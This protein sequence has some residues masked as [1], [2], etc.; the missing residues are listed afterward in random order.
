MEPATFDKLGPT[1]LFFC[2]STNLNFSAK[3]LIFCS[4]LLWLIQTHGLT[5][6]TLL[7]TKG[8]V[9]RYKKSETLRL[10][11]IHKVTAS[12]LCPRAE[13]I[14][15]LIDWF[16]IINCFIQFESNNAKHSLNLNFLDVSFCFCWSYTIINWMTLG[17]G[18][19]ET[20][21]EYRKWQHAL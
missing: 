21:N 7:L 19:H 1:W 18:M 12:F 17:F 5:V 11:G 14:S 20:R 8:K 6:T 2:Q 15:Q 13:M 16:I 4:V 10:G 3:R 9:E